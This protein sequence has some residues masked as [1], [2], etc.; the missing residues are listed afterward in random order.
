MS[1]LAIVFLL[2]ATVALVPLAS[3]LGLGAAMA[4]LLAGVIAG[5][6][7]LG[8]LADPASLAHA[9]EFGVVI[10]LFLIGL[11]LRPRE[12]WRLRGPLVALG[13]AQVVGTS[14]LLFVVAWVLGLEVRT[15]LAIGVAMAMS[16]TAL[17]L[18]AL[19]ERGLGGG[20]AGNG[21][22]S[23]LLFQDIAVIPLLALL[24]LLAPGA[25]T[26]AVQ[27]HS[28]L[29]AFPSAARTPVG[30]AVL[31]AVLAATQWGAKHVFRWLARSRQ[32][33]TMTAM[34]LLL[35]SGIA[36]VAGSVG[37]SAALG[38]FLGGVLLADSEYLHEIEA[39]L[40]PFRGLFLG[41]F[42]ATVGAG[43]NLPLLAS[44]PLQALGIALAIFAF[45]GAV[46]LFLATS[47]R[48]PKS[49][50]LPLALGLAQVG[51]FAFVLLGLSKGLGIVD[52]DLAELLGGAVALSMPLT[53][54]ALAV[55]WSRRRRNLSESK[56]VETGIPE[57]IP[58]SEAPVL[59][60]GYG[61][62]G[63]MVGRVLKSQ[64][65][66]VTVLDLDPGQVAQMRR[67]GLSPHFGDARRAELLK[68][69][70]L[71][72]ARLLVV[73]VDDQGDALEIVETARKLRPDIP[74]L[75]RVRDHRGAYGAL[76]TEN[77][78]PFRETVGTALD[79]ARTALSRLGWREARAHRAVEL[80]RRHNEQSVRDLAVLDEGSAD[81]LQLLRTRIDE[82]AHLVKDGSEAG[83][84]LD[85]AW[86]NES[87]RA[88]ATGRKG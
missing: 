67:L 14:A 17:A 81:W 37:L 16:S 59:L 76:R 88:E 51:E 49:D 25:V 66:G 13:G 4:Y 9:A 29:E 58:A 7:V 50:R 78:M 84:V 42:F 20:P 48:M 70:G 54:V 36:L 62:L 5:P 85:R 27:G 43:L 28:L 55:W 63:S 61:R 83:H 72:T 79:I 52:A 26:E 68:V 2:G 44:K 11:E 30:I 15:A 38:A 6:H 23:I 3:R 69:A 45:K 32:H 33:E 86:D 57:E 39:D 21:A 60:A 40:E 80:F 12:L 24:P 8:L 75:L 34:A 53:P 65:I 19:K 10:M 87:L 46:L 47:A 74:V 18:P 41:F 22:L 56:S 82:A 31:A 1:L 71:A 35:V 73:A 64:G 77:V